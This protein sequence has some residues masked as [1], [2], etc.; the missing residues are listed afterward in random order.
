MENLL[1]SIRPVAPN[2]STSDTGYWLRLQERLRAILEPEEYGTW[3]APLSVQR[4]SEAGLVLVAPNERFVHP[5]E[6]SY[7]ET[8]DR[9]SG[10]LFNEFFSF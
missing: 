4:E 6:E 3:F 5:L 1:I 2:S 9:E 8:L 10:M 7:R